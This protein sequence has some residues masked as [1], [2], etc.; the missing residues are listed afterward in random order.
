MMVV[1]EAL[2]RRVRGAVPVLVLAALLA[3]CGSTGTGAPSASAS[4]PAGATAAIP[5]A[6]TGSAPTSTP[7]APSRDEAD[8]TASTSAT[9]SSSPPTGTLVPIVPDGSGGGTS[10]VCPT[11][12]LSVTLGPGEGTTSGTVYRPLVF[13]NTGSSACRLQGFPGVSHVAGD[14]GHQVGRAGRGSGRVATR[15]RSPRGRPPTRS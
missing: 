7:P 10:P 12:S 9:S 11:S 15:S 5:T 8:T 2:P 3:S 6:T 14:D 13:T 1:R 4:G